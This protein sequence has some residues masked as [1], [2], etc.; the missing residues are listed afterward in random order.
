VAS[1][2]FASMELFS[3]SFRLGSLVVV[4]S[5]EMENYLNLATNKIM[6]RCGHTTLM[7]LYIPLLHRPR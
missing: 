1:Q 4:V 2:G 3:F 7:I 5:I 6:H